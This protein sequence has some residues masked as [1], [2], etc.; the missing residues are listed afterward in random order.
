VA[1]TRVQHH[2]DMAPLRVGE[3]GEDRLEIGELA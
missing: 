3:R 2:Q 1:A